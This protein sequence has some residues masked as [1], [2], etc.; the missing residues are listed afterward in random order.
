MFLEFHMH[1][2]LRILWGW[3]MLTNLNALSA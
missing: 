2:Y 3:Y 1:S